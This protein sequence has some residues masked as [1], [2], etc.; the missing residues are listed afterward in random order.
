M[1]SLVRELGSRMP[2]VAAKKR[3]RKRKYIGVPALKKKK[4][5]LKGR[6][7]RWTCGPKDNVVIS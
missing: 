2:H 3:K 4:K 6:V 5:D 1:R 7:G